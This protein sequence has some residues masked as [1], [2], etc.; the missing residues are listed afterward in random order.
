MICLSLRDSTFENILYD[1]LH[2]EMGR[3]FL[4]EVGLRYF[5]I[6]AKKVELVAP[7]I[8][9]FSIQEMRCSRSFLIRDQK[10]L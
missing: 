10:S 5:G 1:A 9:P 2:K 4:M 7:P 6:R 8:L 3:N